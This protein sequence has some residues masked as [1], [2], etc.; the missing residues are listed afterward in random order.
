LPACPDPDS[1]GTCVV[2]PD[3]AAGSWMP[4]NPQGYASWFDVRAA[5]GLA[6]LT[7]RIEPFPDQEPLRLKLPLKRAVQLLKQWR[8]RA[9]RTRSALAPISIVLTTLAAGHY[10]GETSTAGALSRILDSIVGSLHDGSRLQ[11]PNPTNA[12]EDLSERW[13]SEPGTYSAFIESITAFHAAWPR[14]LRDQRLG[15]LAV[16]L[17]QLFGE[18]VTKGAIRSQAEASEKA[19]QREASGSDGAP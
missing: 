8:D 19:R 4:S 14:L 12:K 7:K 11:V 3:R 6:E 1:G 17:G 9:Y 5:S 15:R 16:G 18:Q 2:V 10:A 13:D